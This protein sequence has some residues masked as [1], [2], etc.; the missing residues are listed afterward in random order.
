MLYLKKS[1]LPKA[2]KGLF[3]DEKFTRGDIICEYEGEI[4][5]WSV[6]L[7]R[8]EQGYEGYV[9]FI[10]KNHCI[11]AYFTPEAMGRYANDA[12]GVSRV[13]G[14]RNNAQYEIKVRDG[15]KRAFIVATRTINPS[16]EIFVDYGQDYWKNLEKLK[17]QYEKMMQEQKEKRRLRKLE[18]EAA[19]KK[20]AR[21]SSTLSKGKKK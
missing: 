18:K 1:K 7:D 21:K 17:P 8:A 6:C 2:G 11:D 3:T 10:S 12:R 5:P 13:D 15:K 16:E 20:S 4:V 14:L 9:F 19:Q